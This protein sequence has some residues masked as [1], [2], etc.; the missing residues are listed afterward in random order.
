MACFGINETTKKEPDFDYYSPIRIVID[1]TCF[2]V[3]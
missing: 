3:M 1:S 2:S